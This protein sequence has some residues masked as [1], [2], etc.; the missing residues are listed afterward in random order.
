[1]KD[2]SKKTCT[3]EKVLSIGTADISM[4]VASKTINSIVE[5]NLCIQAEMSMKGSSIM[6]REKAKEN[7]FPEIMDIH[8]MGIGK[9]EGSMGEER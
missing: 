1:M 5:V 3:T 7:I 2:S 9:R 6:V 4:K 8:M